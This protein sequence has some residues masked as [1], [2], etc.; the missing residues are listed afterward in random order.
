MLDRDQNSLQRDRIH[1][2]WRRAIGWIL[3]LGLTVAILVWVF[4]HLDLDSFK[5]VVVSPHWIPLLGMALTGLLFI[6][7]GGVKLW[8]LVRVFA[9]IRLPLFVAYYFVTGSVGSLIPSWLGDASMVALLRSE[10]I[11]I[12]Q[13][14]SAVAVDRAITLAIYAFVFT[15]CT[16]T[17]LWNIDYVFW[18]ALAF[19]V[20][21]GGIVLVRLSTRLRLTW[22][23]RRWPQLSQI[24]DV[25]SELLK[26]HPLNLI[27]NIFVTLIRCLLSGISVQWALLAA[28]QVGELFPT[29]CIANSLSIISLLPIALGGVGVYEGSG[30]VLFKAIGLN[31][32][33]VFAALVY[34]RIW[35]I[36]SSAFIVIAALILFPLKQRAG[37]SLK[38]RKA[39]TGQG[40]G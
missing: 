27:G 6:L 23:I 12:R 30:L 39:S 5:Q 17:I 16:A 28:G 40:G 36:L 33:A 24:W 3:R 18:L 25:L 4:W 21:I 20:A 9:P 13:G 14:L 15:P 2:K 34:Q 19:A 1:A 32:E 7:A 38:A 35:I 31:S 37:W 22:I 26:K 10:D 29:T 8:L 11:P